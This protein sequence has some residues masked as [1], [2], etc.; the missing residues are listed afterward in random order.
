[1][2]SIVS[3]YEYDI[4]ISYRQKDNK[5]DGWVTEFVN[6]LKGELESTFKEEISV[7]F[8]INPHDGLLETHD[9][10]ASLKEKLKCLIFIP[11]ISRTY[12]DPKS[13][14]W[15]YE[16][17][18]F[19]EQASN[20]QFGLKVKLPGGNVA[21]RI[22]PVQIHDLDSNDKSLIENELKGVLRPIEFIYKEAG[23]NR[24][25]R[26]TE[27]NPTC[28]LN[29]T[30]YRN[31]VNKVAL[32]TKEIFDGLKADN[33]LPDKDSNTITEPYR[34]LS[35]EPKQKTSWVSS[36]PG[37]L[38][39]VSGTIVLVIL[40]ITAILLYPK[41]FTVDKLK[42]LR[43]SDGRIAVAVFPFQNMTNDTTWNV[44]QDGIQSLLITTLSNSEELKVRQP[45]SMT[46]LLHSKGITNYASITPSVARTLSQNLEAN[47]F[48]YGS[49]NQAGAIIRLNAQMIDSKTE[50][51]F[52][53][54]QIDGTA[55]KILSSID[56]LSARVKDFLII[57]KLKKE[58]SSHLQNIVST[59]SPDAFR[60]FI[61]AYKAWDTGDNSSAINFIHQSLAIDSGFPA[62]ML[63][64]SYTYAGLGSY[65]EAKNWCLHL[66]DKR[67]KMPVQL[68]IRIN[69]LYSLL[70]ETPTEEIRSLN[71][72]VDLDDQWPGTY[73]NLANSYSRLSE[74]D[75]AIP[76]LEKAFEIFAKRDS[77]PESV[78]YYNLL[79]YAYQETGQYKKE[80]ALY[81][82]CEKD[83][84]DN[85][86]LLL[87]QS[88]LYLNEGDSAA[89]NLSINKYI[90]FL[91]SYSLPEADLL[92]ARA[93][94]YIEANNPGTGEKDLREA[95]NLEPENPKYLSSL[96]WFLINKDRNINEGLTLVEKALKSSPEDFNCLLTKGLG[97]YKLGKFQEACEILQKSW[98]LR[99]KYSIYDHTAFIHLQ[100]AKRAV[101]G[102]KKI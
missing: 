102:K 28:N 5:H 29:K 84:P 63:L 24:P 19:I 38:K 92:L 55:E 85:Y 7:Y 11:I 94:I 73:L 16:F 91:K 80:K 59:N 10:S 70:F 15:E 2:A 35:S 46:G 79:G 8:D 60:Y 48:I 88:I 64:L 40:I 87:L 43:S 75:K 4:F 20:D 3:G 77:K 78:D 56:S 26:S 21:N 67:E 44:W 32:A 6:N 50:E 9:V 30:I 22:L 12:C 62:A 66:Y 61:Y 34:K 95:L 37:Y 81:K 54:F 31:Q 49:V 99:Q 90:S 93:S 83:Y 45:E 52:R 27:E 72:L 1:M 74:Y 51:V 39:I 86:Q 17:K 41:L 36:R 69:H 13:F 71:Q 89:A 97:L 25:L 101:A 14:A 47:V 33:V 98:N 42:K 23:V 53:S 58:L 100:E 57:S 18:A 65:V 68:K 96:A 76:E 82:Q